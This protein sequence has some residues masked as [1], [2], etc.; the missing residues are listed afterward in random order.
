M[1]DAAYKQR[2]HAKEGRR[3]QHPEVPLFTDRDV[4]RC[5][6]Q[7]HGVSYG[8]PLQLGDNVSVTFFDAGHILGSAMLEILVRDREP[9]LR[10]LFSG[11]VGQWNRPLVRDPTL[12]REANY[13]VM[14]STYGD[15]LHEDHGDVE[16]QLSDVINRTLNRGGNVVIPTFRRRASP[17][18]DV[19]HRAA[20]ARRADSRGQG[21]S[22]QPDGRRCDRGLSTV[23]RIASMPRRSS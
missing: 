2:R 12:F 17:G 8:E 11:D 7:F 22:G 6:P 3:G 21:L 4:E 1:E 9:P 15:R 5:L 19:P 20:G 10:L 16:T 13:V 14:E 18:A 23:S